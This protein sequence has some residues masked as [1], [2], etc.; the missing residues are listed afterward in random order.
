MKI[1]RLKTGCRMKDL[2]SPKQVAR[3]IGVSESSLKRW[4]DRGLIEFTRTAGGHRKLHTRS[5]IEFL[6]SSGHELVD[7]EI[8]GLPST[9]GH[10]ERTLNAAK[11][12][13]VQSLITGDETACRQI[14]IDLYLA[15]NRISQIGDEVIGAAFRQVGDLWDCGDVEVYQERLSCEI[16]IRILHELRA[17]LPAVKQDAPVAIGGTLDGDQYTLGTTLV[18]LVLRDNGWNATSLGNSLPFSTLKAAIE[19]RQ[20]K[21]FWLSVSYIRDED[22]FL[23]EVNNLYE[24][25]RKHNIAFAAG[26]FALTEDV[27]KKMKYSNFCDTMQHLES[28]AQTLVPAS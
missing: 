23:K 5:V 4:C 27:R 9:S 28:F 7:P 16:C 3:A 19:T 10:G 12:R 17:M 20:P 8:L 25:T 13:L 21:L 14:I 1:D 18:E 6:K 15:K 2:V 24:L 11:N 22:L 26:G